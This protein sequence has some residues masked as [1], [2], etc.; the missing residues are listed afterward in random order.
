MKR[1]S[2]APRPARKGRDRD[3]ENTLPTALLPGTVPVTHRSSSLFMVKPAYYASTVK[4]ME[5]QR[6]EV[7]FKS[8]KKVVEARFQLIYPLLKLIFLNPMPGE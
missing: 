4:E 6:N 1:K 5:T 8:H 7:I 3:K 2:R